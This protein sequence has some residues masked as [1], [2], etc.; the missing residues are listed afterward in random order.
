MAATDA[1]ESDCGGA[2]C[3]TE[4]I[5]KPSITELT[6]VRTNILCTVQGCG[7]ILPNTPA[8]N[9]HLV[10]SHRV[11]VFIYLQRINAAS[12]LLNNDFIKL[13]MN[14]YNAQ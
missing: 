6:K 14:S 7:K 5:I 13:T 11:K 3:P 2:S 1:G 9:M 12:L 4:E 10:K 8:L